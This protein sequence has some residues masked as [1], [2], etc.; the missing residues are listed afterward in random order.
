MSDIPRDLFEAWRSP[1][2]GVENPT[3]HDNPLWASLVHDR[4]NA[5]QVN[6]RYGHE[7][8]RGDGPTWCFDRFGQSTTELPDGRTVYIGGEHEDYYDPD[9]C[10]YNDVFVH[11]GDGSITIF[12]YPEKV[13]PPTDFHTA[14]LIDE[15]IY[16]I[17]SLG[18]QGTRRFGHTPVHR[19]DVRTFQIETVDATGESPGWIYEHRARLVGSSDIRIWGG[20]IARPDGAR[21]TRDKNDATFVLNID[22]LQWRREH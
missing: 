19:L 20:K 8:K 13:F 12:G 3:R 7:R 9:F 1:R 5:W 6:Q 21:E 15:A 17:G 10:I 22:R 4:V 14:T 16:V 18:Y 11:G 2:F